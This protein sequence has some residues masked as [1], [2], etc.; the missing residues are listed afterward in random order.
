MRHSFGILDSAFK[1]QIPGTS[2]I[3]ADRNATST[4]VQAIESSHRRES[5]IL[6]PQPTNDPNDPLNWSK[7]EK[8][9]VLLTIAIASAIIHAL[10]PMMSTSYLQIARQFNESLDKITQTVSGNFALTAGLGTVLVSAFG[11][12]YGKR[13]ALVF[14]AV[15][16]SALT[17]W[18]ALEK[19]FVRFAVVRALQGL[20][21][22]PLEV[23]VTGTVA[24]LYFVHERGTAMAVVGTMMLLSV[25]LSQI[26]GGFAVQYLGFRSLFYITA[27]LIGLLVPAL[28]FLVPGIMFFN[29]CRSDH[30]NIFQRLLGTAMTPD[31]TFHFKI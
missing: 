30:S 16:V 8:R 14:S 6:V 29:T 24:D 31:R 9:V 1:G 27:I 26:M 19:N 22:A 12:C 13:P 28:F 11:I 20:A 4:T 17:L 23:L 7:I 5:V 3:T 2:I 18:I 25:L 21:T 15:S 10:G